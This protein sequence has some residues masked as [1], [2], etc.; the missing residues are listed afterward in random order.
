M[1]ITIVCAYAAIKKGTLVVKMF[2]RLRNVKNLY[3]GLE[4]IITNNN[5]NA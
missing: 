3:L 1:R 5:N 2:V 4:E